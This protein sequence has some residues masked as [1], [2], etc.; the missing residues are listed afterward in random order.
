MRPQ[1]EHQPAL[2]DEAEPTGPTFILQRN[3]GR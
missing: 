3:G 2:L 1:A